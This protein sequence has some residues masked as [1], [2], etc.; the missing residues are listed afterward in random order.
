MR[1]CICIR[2]SVGRSIHSCVSHSATPPFTR[3]AMATTV[4][5]ASTR[6]R[7]G[8]LPIPALDPVTTADFPVRSNIR[9]TW[10][11]VVSNSRSIRVGF[12]TVRESKRQFLGEN[13]A[14]LGAWLLLVEGTVEERAGFGR[15]EGSLL[16]RRCVIHTTLGM[17][18]PRL[19]FSTWC[20]TRR[21]T[22]AAASRSAF[23]SAEDG[24]PQVILSLSRIRREVK[25]EI[26]G[27]QSS[28]RPSRAVFV[29]K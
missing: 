20:P 12:G 11:I 22:R 25:S 28:A 29:A 21:S 17:A 1:S 3:R 6:V 13:Y 18:S 26:V 2:A 15:S 10:S 14:L 9:M 5:P 8:R 23:C 4:A 16:A 19:M 7:A 24:R 27:A